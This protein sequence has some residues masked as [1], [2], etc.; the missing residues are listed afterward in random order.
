M[1]LTTNGRYHHDD[2]PNLARVFPATCGA[3]VQPRHLPT[4]GVRRR[5]IV[6]DRRIIATGYNGAPSGHPHCTDVGCDMLDGHCQRVIHAEVNAIGQAAQLGIAVAGATMYIHRANVESDGRGP[7]R[8]CC[9][10]MK[11]AGIW[12]YYTENGEADMRHR[13][14]A[15]DMLRDTSDIDLADVPDH[16]L[17]ARY[18]TL[19]AEQVKSMREQRLI[20][21]VMHHDMVSGYLMTPAIPAVPS[22][23]GN[24]S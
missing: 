11:A 13:L 22:K 5:R 6:K 16:R 4:R 2:P 10:V 7:C 23:E 15:A 17:I 8:E 12:D 9:K 20:R 1:P 19:P 14:T 18:G 21:K 24:H 3:S